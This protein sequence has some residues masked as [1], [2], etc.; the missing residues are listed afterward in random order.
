MVNGFGVMMSAATAVS[1]SMARARTLVTMSRSVMMPDAAVLRSLTIMALMPC[2]VIC[3]AIFL[4][5]V[6]GEHVFTGVDMISE[7]RF[8]KG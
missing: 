4:I 6:D 7:R 2:F 1:Q 3:W 8:L 5:G